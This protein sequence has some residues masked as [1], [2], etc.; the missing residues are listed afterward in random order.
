MSAETVY[1]AFGPKP[2]LV[3]A[4]WLRGLAGR[5]P[6]P[7]PE[8]S[9]AL[10]AAEQDPLEIVRDWAA[11]MKQ[12]AP[13]VAPIILLIRAAA[14]HDS[15]MAAL[16]EEVDDQRRQRMRHNADRLHRRGWLRPG[17]GLDEAADIL[18][19]YS[20]QEL[21]ELLVIKSGWSIDRYADFAGDA[22]I[23][24]LLR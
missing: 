16:L 7:A 23:A 17:L 24:T 20:S 4:L 22:M 6:V 2:A 18:W 8:R 15:A 12:V 11:L 10:S 13:E 1:K 9:D 14:V 3:R 5:G 19:T 21:Y